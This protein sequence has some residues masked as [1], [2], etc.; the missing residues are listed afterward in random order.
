MRSME[1]NMNAK[2]TRLVSDGPMG[3]PQIR[4]L[5]FDD[6]KAS[7]ADGWADFRAHTG[8]GLFFGA[9]YMVGGLL[10]LAFLTRIG[11]PWMIIPLAIGFPLLGPFVAVGLYEISRR[12]HAGEPV[13]RKGVLAQV[14][15]QRERQLG[16]MAFVVMFIFWVWIYQVRLLLALFL[17]FKSFSS[18]DAFVQVVISTPEGWGFLLVG[19]L[20]GTFLSTVLYST[21]VI[22]LPMLAEREV[23]F[24]TAMITSIATVVKNPVPMLAFGVIIGATTLLALLPAF[25]GLLVALPV[26]GHATWHLYRRATSPV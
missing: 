7:L 2:Q 8:F 23:D 1:E 3:A 21:T 6:I 13:T 17:G 18:W 26:L 12:R 16:W 14:F 11:S 15:H 20:V 22:A 25:A 19:T 4:T 5:S 10:I 9:I 24:V